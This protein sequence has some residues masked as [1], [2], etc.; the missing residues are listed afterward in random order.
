MKNEW[1]DFY[2]QNTDISYPAEGVIRIF[3]GK[4]PNLDLSDLKPGCKVLDL[5]AGDGRHLAFFD[6]L[7][8]DTHGIEI[9]KDI[10][11]ALQQKLN[12]LDIKASVKEGMADNIPYPDD[13][14]DVILA[15]NSCYYMESAKT[16]FQDH[17]KEIARPLKS[18]GLLVCSV[19]QP[20][21]F[22]FKDADY[23][24]SEKKYKTV[25]DDFFGLRNGQVMRCLQDEKDIEDSFSKY[26]SNFRHA[27]ISLEWFGLSYD[28]YVFVA[29][30]N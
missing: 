29:Q 5:G 28:W 14:F 4:F 25:K 22:I 15:W 8:F 16:D 24:D 19:P 26:F 3:K 18:G 9:S 13:F 1:T 27:K 23:T 10:C 30:K 21:S 7:G 20:S 17:V 11:K 6:K 2:K 12:T